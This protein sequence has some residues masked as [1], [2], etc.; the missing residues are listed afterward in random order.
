MD[1]VCPLCF[2]EM[3]MQTYQDERESTQTCFKLKC[4]HAFHTKCIVECLQKTGHECPSCNKHKTIADDLTEEGLVRQLVVDMKKL[5][6]VRDALRETA[7][8]RTDVL[9]TINLIKKDAKVYAKERAAELKL[10][11]KQA[12]M[13][14]CIATAKKVTLE[15][16]RKKSPMHFAA[17]SKVSLFRR[18]TLLELCLL[19]YANTYQLHRLRNPYLSFAL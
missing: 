9:N 17:A 10:K 6:A 14:T 5:P 7:I 4:N 3:D 15:E 8:A 16:A 19:G 11:E 12:Y 18:T 1:N 13:R 2:E